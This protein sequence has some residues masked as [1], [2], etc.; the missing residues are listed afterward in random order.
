MI[1]LDEEFQVAGMWNSFD[2]LDLTRKSLDDAKCHTGGGGCPAILLADEANGWLHSNSLNYIPV[3]GRLHGLNAGT[4]L[5]F[6]D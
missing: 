1:D 4:E 2:H 6:E 5:G 3:H